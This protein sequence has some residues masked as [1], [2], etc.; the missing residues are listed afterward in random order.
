MRSRE[1]D[2]GASKNSWR[3]RHHVAVTAN[4]KA[5]FFAFA[6]RALPKFNLVRRLKSGRNK[7]PSVTGGLTAGGFSVHVMRCS[8]AARKLRALLTANVTR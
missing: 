7:Q 1:V 3:R 4:N 5:C 6:Q 8:D 2:G